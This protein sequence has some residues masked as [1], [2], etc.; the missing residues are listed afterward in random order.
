MINKGRYST[1]ESNERNTEN[2]YEWHVLLYERSV[3]EI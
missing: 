3:S 1:V 2:G